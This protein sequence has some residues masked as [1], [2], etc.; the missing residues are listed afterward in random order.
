V[1]AEFDPIAQFQLIVG[2]TG[3]R[4]ELVLR[5]ELKDES[6]EKDQLSSRLLERFPQVCRVRPDSIAW[7]PRGTIPADRQT[8]VDE[9]RWE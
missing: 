9:R 5:I 3:E 6:I 1:L 4:D 2:R 7:V 8:I